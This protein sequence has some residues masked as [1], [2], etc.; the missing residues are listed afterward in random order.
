MSLSNRF[1]S[2]GPTLSVPLND[3]STRENDDNEQISTLQDYDL[4]IDIE[5]ELLRILSSLP[6]EATDKEG[7]QNDHYQEPSIIDSLIY[8][9]IEDPHCLVDDYLDSNFDH[10]LEED[11]SRDNY[12][13]VVS[14]RDQEHYNGDPFPN[15][16][17]RILHPTPDQ[18]MLGIDLVLNFEIIPSVITRSCS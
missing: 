1:S 6:E 11:Q 15:D 14:E 16:I 18:D 8:E 2:P 3:P 12:D 4:G 9:S 10:I 7:E 5:G 17:N 13:M